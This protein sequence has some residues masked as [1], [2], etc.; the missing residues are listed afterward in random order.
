MRGTSTD[1]LTKPVVIWLSLVHD[2]AVAGRRGAPDLSL[3]TVVGWGEP[4][5]S[6]LR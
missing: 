3:V 5:R 4:H 2:T 6:D 1:D